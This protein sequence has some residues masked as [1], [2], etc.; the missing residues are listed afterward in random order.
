[1]LGSRR[2]PGEGSGNPLWYPC[3]GE[4]NLAGCSPWGHKEP[5][6]TE[7]LNNNSTKNIQEDFNKEI[8]QV[9]G[10][11]SI[12]SSSM[13]WACEIF[14]SSLVLQETCVLIIYSYILFKGK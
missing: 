10:I 3:H 8:D 6:I 1:M 7:Q 5:D 4:K 14:N 11:L 9:H 2:S 13:R 12:G